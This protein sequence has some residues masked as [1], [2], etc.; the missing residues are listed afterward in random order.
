MIFITHNA[1]IPVWLKPILLIVMN[2][3]G[4]IGYIEKF[5]LGRRSP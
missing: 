5:R 2:S 1:N 4:E 3:D